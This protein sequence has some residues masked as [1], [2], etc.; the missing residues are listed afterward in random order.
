MW[1][2]TLMVVGSDNGGPIY[3]NGG[4]NNYPLKGGKMSDWQGGV[5]VNASMSGGFLP[6]KMRGQKI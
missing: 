5:G 4:A 6:E 3:P 2:N 1:D